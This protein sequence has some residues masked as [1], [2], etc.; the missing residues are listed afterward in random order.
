MKKP[1]PELSYKCLEI[2]KRSKT[3]KASTDEEHKLCTKIFR[4]YKEW[5]HKSERL[6]FIDTLPFGVDYTQYEKER[7]ELEK[8]LL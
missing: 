5:Y 8:E 4:K 6:V 7:T 3:G 1:S 2:R